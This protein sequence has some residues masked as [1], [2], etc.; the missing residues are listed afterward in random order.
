MI[1]GNKEYNLLDTHRWKTE[2]KDGGKYNNFNCLCTC[3]NCHRLIHAGKITI[4]G[5]Y[6]STSGKVLN[7][8]DENEEEHMNKI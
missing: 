8:I 1:C 7:Y 6:N 5:V 2:G 4:I 3:A